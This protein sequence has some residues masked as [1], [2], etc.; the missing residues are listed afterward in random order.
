MLILGADGLGKAAACVYRPSTDT[1][2]A[3]RDKEGSLPDF[4]TV[5]NPLLEDTSG[6]GMASDS[7]ERDGIINWLS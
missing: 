5:I 4:G 1:G 3:D 6:I 7:F 2:E